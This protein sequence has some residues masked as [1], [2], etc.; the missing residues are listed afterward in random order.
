LRQSLSLKGLGIPAHKKTVY[1]LFKKVEF[2]AHIAVIVIAVLLGVVLVKR[3][4]LTHTNKNTA[5]PEIT[6]GT[7]LSLPGIDWTKSGLTMLLVLSK[8]CRYCTES[9]AF[10]Q[11]LALEKAKHANTRL[12]AVFPQAVEVGQN[13]LTD[14]GVAV[15]D[16]K[17]VTPTDLGVRG[18]PTLILVDGTGTVQ[19]VWPGK[20]P[21]DKE[22]EVLNELRREG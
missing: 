13:Y 18:T 14:I 1:N 8:D 7:R 10:Y 19:K 4:L 3:F 16:V 21:P 2:L 15:D 11:R 5:R 12:I 6:V 20:L 17:K 22:S 9:A